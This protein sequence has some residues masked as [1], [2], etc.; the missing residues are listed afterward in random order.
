MRQQR[1]V[2]LTSEGGGRQQSFIHTSGAKRAE[3]W[4]GGEIGE[5]WPSAWRWR[6]D[7]RERGGRRTNDEA[8]I[9]AVELQPDFKAIQVCLIENIKDIKMVTMFEYT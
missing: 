6:R 7:V 4:R 1:Q 3:T 2:F 5:S 8:S 9:R